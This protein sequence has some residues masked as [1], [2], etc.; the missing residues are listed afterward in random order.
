[1][2]QWNNSYV[3]NNQY[4]GENTWNG[5]LNTQYANQGYYPNPNQQYDSANQQYVS[6]N[7]FINQMQ[8]NGAP[9]PSANNYNSSQYQNYGQYDYQNMPST[10][11][12]SQVDSYYAGNSSNSQ[13]GA[14]SYN[15]SQYEQ[16]P[17]EQA[18]YSNELILK[19]NLTPTASEFVPKS[20]KAKPSRS[21]Q[22]VPE[23]TNSNS[24]NNG[25]TEYKKSHGSSSDTNW[26]ERPQSSQ[27]NG[28]TKHNSRYQDNYRHQE[29]SNRNR[30]RDRDRNRYQDSNSHNYE[31]N[32]RPDRNQSKSNGKSKKQDAD[33]LTFYNSSINKRGQDHRNGKGEGSGR[34]RNWAGSQRLRAERNYTEDEQYANS[35]LQYKEEKA[36]RLAKQDNPSPKFRNKQTAE[37][38]HTEMTQ[39]ERLSEQLDKGTLECLVCCERVKQIDP[40][41]SCG[42]CYHVLHLRCIRKW[43]MSSVVEGKWRCPACQNT[44]EEIPTEYRCMC[45]AT[46]APEYQRGGSGAH[47][48]GK[49][50]KRPRA[51]PHPCTLLCHPGPCPPC[52]A[53]VSK[54][55]GC[56]A[57]TRSV[58]CSSKLPQVCGR[59]CHKTLTCGA[60]A[61]QAPCHEGA[62]QDCEETV[63]QVC[64]CPAA[65]SRSVPCTRET[66][67]QQQ[68]SC[69]SACA[70]VLACGR[71]VCTLACHAPP[72][73]P[74]RLLPRLVLTCPCGKN[75]LDKDS[76]KSCTDPIPLCGGIC[77]KPLPCGP[78]G[79]KHFCKLDCHE[80]ECPVCPDKT[81]VQCRCGHSSREVPCAEL[82]QMINNVLCQKK[83]NKK[84]SC[85]R[86][87][88]RTVCCAASS[89]RCAVV[90]ART[91]S[92]QLHRCEEFC[93]TGH[94]APCPRVSFEEL[95]CT[96]GAQV[97]LPPVRCGARP[98]AC[99]APCRRRRA[100]LHPPH[101]SCHTGDCPPCVVLTT[102]RCHGQHEVTGRQYTRSL[103]FEELL[104]RACLHPPHHSCHTGDC[105]PCVVLT[106]KRCHGQHEV[107]GRQY[108]RSLGFEE[109]LRRACLHPPHHSCH[110]GD[111]PPCVVLT[112]K[113][114]HGQH[115]VTGRQY[116]RSL[117]FEELLRR[118]CLHPPH[119]SCHTGD[120]PPCVVLTTKR[121]HGQHEVTGRQYTRSLGF[122]ELLRRACL[123][124]PHHS[125]HTGDCPPCV[126]LTTK[127]CHGQHEV[128]GR[129]YTRSLGFEELL[130]RACLHPPHHSCHTG[131]CPPCV[132][133]TTKRCHG[134]HEERKTIPCSQDEFSCGLPCGKPLPC[135]KHTCIKTCHKGECDT[136]KCTQPCNEKRPSC[137]HPCAAPC[138]SGTGA[139]CPS[140]A[141]CR[142][143]VR[144]TCACGRRSADRACA[145]NARDY[146]K[147]M[148]ALAAT[149]MQEGGSVDLSDVQRPGSML[150]TLDC[151][152]ECRVEART[153]QMA[154]ALQI[155]NPDVSAKLAPRYSDTLRATAAREPAFAQQIH[156]KLTELV[157]LAKKSKQKTRAHSFPS[158]NWQKRQ[159]IHELCEHF[160]CESVA[161]DAEPNRNV[162][163]T[164]DRE[165]SWL[166][167]MSILEVVQREAGKRKVPGPVLRPPAASSAA[168]AAAGNKP[169][170]WATLT[171]TNAWAARSQPK[172]QP[173]PPPQDKLDYFDYPPDN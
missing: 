18:S 153:R 6:F 123:H 57:E 155:R 30:D 56:G 171:S 37:T 52:Q 116:T 69:G 39:R 131:D 95:R 78:A 133:L 141:P 10:S 130:R 58:L 44:S 85:G 158:M 129:Q 148:S 84:L 91:L 35:Y 143:P 60:H 109:L 120:C 81:L 87:R 55:C 146:N 121:C 31:S 90:C 79:D 154:L 119:H 33:G 92:C 49:A 113:R 110:T 12:N 70:R 72:C 61:C 105:P 164:A 151:D 4:Q 102:K 101:H 46:R 124:P 17:Q 8:G 14:E 112:T 63:T 103:G 99:D 50:C 150:K 59:T 41:W 169:S 48:C 3:Y 80:G 167:A 149:K 127:R 5:D 165:K 161:Y 93:H 23:T 67:S 173:Q 96:C 135:G 126:V 100:C 51:C 24:S 53:T 75:K 34:N 88:C 43:A 94:C 140:A 89:H 40:V 98:P 106:T 38:A 32:N 28:E 45:G 36:E 111:C 172:P 1:M 73:A 71:H 11:Q 132:V 142:R 125:C 76:R 19:S 82:P 29:N 122:E 156:D 138:H 160:G 166:P 62:C 20:T 134:Q 54:K 47:T 137:G 16:Q 118:A 168:A 25:A 9:Q 77:A 145:D 170:G 139:P 144:A 108:T 162:V 26:R 7:E 117:G 147:M 27:Q 15:Q 21:V 83:C 86:H 2:S 114:C 68:W 115:E 136:S 159:F 42:N 104:R 128:T 13:N 97:L 65:K 22:N 152:D 64:Y 107:T 66:G 157:H 163:A 74:C